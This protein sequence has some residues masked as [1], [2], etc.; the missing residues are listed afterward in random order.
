MNNVGTNSGNKILMNLVSGSEVFFV[1]D[2]GLN[3]ASSIAG[4]QVGNR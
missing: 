4:S 2:N 1:E 3:N